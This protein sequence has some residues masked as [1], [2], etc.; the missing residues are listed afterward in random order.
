MRRYATAVAA[1][2]VL[3]LGAGSTAHA[4]TP[5]P[6]EFGN[7]W[8]DP[9]TATPPIA[10]PDGPSCTIRIVNHQFVNF[11][12]FVGAY[13]PPAECAG[14]W[15][16][17]V[18]TVHGAVRGRQ[19]DRLGRLAIGGA[20]IF[21]T[22]TPEPSVDGIAWTVEKD[23][24]AYS[25]LLSR[26]QQVTMWLGNVVDDTYTGVLD[27]QADLTFYPGGR[28]TGTPDDVLPLADT[29]SD[30]P[31]TTGSLTVARNTERLVAEVYATGSGG[32]CEEFWYIT[33]PSASGYS[34]PADN[35]PY[36]EVQVLVDGEIAGIAMPYPHIYTGGWSNPFLWYAIPAPRAF[37]VAP[38]T[39]DLSPFVGR[40]TD[41]KRHQ[42]RVHVL[43]VPAGQGG[44]E[45]PT[46]FFAWRDAGSAVVAGA[47][48][49]SHVSEL[50]NAVTVG[51]SD[52]TVAAAHKFT[53]VGYVQTSHG[54]VTYNVQRTVGNTSHHVWGEQENPDALKAEWTDNSTVVVAGRQPSITVHNARYLLDGSVIISAENRLTTTFTVTDAATHSTVGPKSSTRWT[55][56]DTFTGTASWTLGVPRPDRHATGTSRQRYQLHGDTCYDHT[57]ATV[58]GY[59][60]EDSSGC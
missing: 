17:V 44:W 21:K 28:P 20:T 1:A 6:S 33:A 48:L 57:I 8:D 29:A 3:L 49:A 39:Y 16:T 43:G 32:G 19:F 5:P 54:R 12:P 22:S 24:T 38:V 30:G 50:D 55:Q 47:L 53:A 46:N 25:A 51:S 45:A 9:R 18:L 13:A 41:G 34:C 56:D 27:I 15:Q 2:M 31:D 23:V 11:D 35:G 59:F 37:N 58:N 52:V 14:P 7:D 36:R 10:R 4:A 40:L 60:T 42:V 26:P